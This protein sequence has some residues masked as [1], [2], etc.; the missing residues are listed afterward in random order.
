VT[1]R[2]TT[3]LLVAFAIFFIMQSPEEAAAFVSATVDAVFDLL[4]AAASAF[5]TFLRS[6]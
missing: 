5:T 2:L 3:L 6:L 4:G 1:K